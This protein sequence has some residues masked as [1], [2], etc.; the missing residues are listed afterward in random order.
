MAH[1]HVRRADAEADGMPEGSLVWFG[2]TVRQDVPWFDSA[3]ADGQLVSTAHDMATYLRFQFG[4]GTWQGS[5]IVSEAGLRSMHETAVPTPPDAAAESTTR[6]GLGWGVGSIGGQELV[7]H[8]GD[9]TGYHADAALLPDTRRAVVVLTAR[10]GFLTDPGSAHRAGLHALVDPDATGTDPGFVRT[11]AVVDAV[12]LLA[13]VAMALTLG[14]RRRW[15]ACLPGKAVRRGRWGALAPTVAADV[16]LAVGLY[17]G[18]TVG[19]GMLLVGFPFPVPLLSTS[20]PDLLCLVFVGIAFSAVKAVLDLRLGL[21]ALRRRPVAERVATPDPAGYRVPA[22]GGTTPV[23]PP[24][25][26]R[27]RS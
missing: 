26:R 7:A 22:R 5:R 9:G 24:A 18:A 2:A 6:Y 17:L 15:A 12:A 8:A 3:L 27:S 21:A 14:R 20:T 23:P 16:L 25:R 11:Y 13:V 4:D 19:V 10:N 1:S